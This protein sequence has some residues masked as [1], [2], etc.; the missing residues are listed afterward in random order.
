MPMD[1]E[2]KSAW[3]QFLTGHWTQE[4]PTKPGTYETTD[5]DGF[6]SHHLVVFMGKPVYWGREMVDEEPD[7]LVCVLGGTTAPVGE[8]RG[9][10]WSEPTPEL[11]TH[12]A[13]ITV[14]TPE[15]TTSKK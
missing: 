8:W 15:T 10:W 13:G 1:K 3:E 14:R 2:T 11:P 7:Q 5:S 6:R 4:P 12:R 9:Y